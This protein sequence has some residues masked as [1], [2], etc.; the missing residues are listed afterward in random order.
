MQ[1]GP[2]GRVVPG[3]HQP[4][5]LRTSHRPPA[6]RGSGDATGR[7]GNH[8]GRPSCVKTSERQQ[9]RSGFPFQLAISRRC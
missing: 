5:T 6:A 8:P 3:R 4:G 1:P 7:F 2:A 9:E